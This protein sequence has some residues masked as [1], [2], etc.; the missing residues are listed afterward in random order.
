MDMYSRSYDWYMAHQKEV[1]AAKGKT[2]RT[3]PDQKLM[4]FV[5]KHLI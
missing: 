4:G 3:S 5:V 1:D 2:H